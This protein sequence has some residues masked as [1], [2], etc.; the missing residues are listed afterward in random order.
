MSIGRSCRSLTVALMLGLES[1][2]NTI[3]EQVTSDFHIKGFQHIHDA[4]LRT[5]AVVCGMAA[6]VGDGVLELVMADNRGAIHATEWEA[7]GQDVVA[8][9]GQLG[10]EVWGSIASRTL[11]ET[12]SGRVLHD[13]VLSAALAMQA[14]MDH[15]IFQ[16]VKQ[17]P[18][19]LVQG[20]L[21][22]RLEELRVAPEPTE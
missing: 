19:S 20:D 9:L 14:F 22:T 4:G 10:P 17:Y 12:V 15:G 2:V 6:K 13:R 11:G 3:M 5:F 7:A 1:L 16:A 8:W 21:E 18:W